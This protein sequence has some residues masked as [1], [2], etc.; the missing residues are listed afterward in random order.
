MR[1]R[2]DKL[3]A[4][5]KYRNIIY[6]ERRGRQK[7]S[8]LPA[9]IAAVL[10]ALCILY[11]LAIFLFIGY[12]TRFFLIWGVIGVVLAGVSYLLYRKDILDIIPV[13]YKS[14]FLGMFSVC[15]LVFVITEALIIKDF[16]FKKA[17]EADYVIVLGAQWKTTGP[18]LV[19]KYRLDTAVSYLKEHPEAR[20]IVSG[21]QGANEPISEA[22]GMAGYLAD[23]GIEPDRIIEENASTNTNQNLLYSSFLLEKEKDSVVI[24][25][26]DF[27][28]F[29]AVG[30]AKQQ[31]YEHVDGLAAPSVKI[32]LPNNLLREFFG[33]W[34]DVMVR[35]MRLFH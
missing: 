19:L 5:D 1:R 32:M 33:V 23:Q 21:G 15:V 22:Q 16:A 34:K 18:S 6:V 26:N 35:N 9:I 4:P 24:V 10:S 25:T 17:P 12:G 28:V 3:I 13:A 29:R 2:R 7:I 20:V 30:I 31:G 14:F 8:Y 11:C 27:H